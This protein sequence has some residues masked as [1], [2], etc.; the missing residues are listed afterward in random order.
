MFVVGILGWRWLGSAFSTLDV[1]ESMVKTR[2]LNEYLETRAI[3]AGTSAFVDVEEGDCTR[4]AATVR[5]LRVDRA[6]L[7]GQD[8]ELVDTATFVVFEDSGDPIPEE[9]PGMS[10]EQVE[11]EL[12]ETVAR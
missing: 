8:P 11:A 1:T 6:A 10:A 9:R 12:C 3:P 7:P 4:W 2:T 5:I